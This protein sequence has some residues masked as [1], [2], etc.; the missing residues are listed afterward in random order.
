MT[1][2]MLVLIGLPASGKST[3]ALKLIKENTNF[4]RISRDDLRMSLFGTEHNPS[5]EG[6]ITS[7]QDSLIKNALHKGKSVVIDNCNIRQQ[8]R[9]DLFKIAESI[10]D[11]TYEEIIFNS[12][13]E[14]CIERNNKRERKVSVEAIIKFAKDGRN[15]IWGNYKPI[16]VEIPKKV[17]HNMQLIQDEKLPKAIMCD[18]DG[19]LAFMNGRNPYD[20]STCDQDIP[21]IPVLKTLKLFV[22]GG[23]KIIF[24]S[25]R[26]DKYREPTIRFIERYFSWWSEDEFRLVPCHYELFMR[27][28]GDSRKDSIVKEEIFNSEICD[29]YNVLFVLDD[30]NQ[31]VE[32]WREIGLTCFQVAPGDF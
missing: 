31:V 23:Y 29:K 14:E 22:S 13:V 30:R 12:S 27:K 25:G 18:L 24:C 8:Y 32:K 26:E 3:F 20:A 7:V 16:K 4:V 10:R 5:V 6:F 9:N 2:K 15:T 17:D 11:V 21:N 1:K 19:T 28:T